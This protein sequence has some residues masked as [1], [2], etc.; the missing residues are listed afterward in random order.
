MSND[1]VT[2]YFSE[3]GVFDFAGA[4]GSGL[5]V[6]VLGVN[7]CPPPKKY[8]YFTCKLALL[9]HLYPLSLRDNQVFLLFRVIWACNQDTHS[10]RP[11]PVMYETW[12]T[13]ACRF[14]S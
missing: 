11:W 10:S 13:G 7:S 9:Y 3:S 1:P 4:T 12:N 5:F 8:Y 2:Q 6:P 14:K